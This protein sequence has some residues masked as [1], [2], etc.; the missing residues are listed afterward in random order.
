M[1]TAA[2]DAAAKRRATYADVS[3]TSF[4]AP[5]VS[6][7]VAAFLSVRPEFVGRPERV[8]Q[9]LVDSAQPL[10][11]ERQFEG[12]GLLDIMRALQSV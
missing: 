3:G 1:A 11:R 6:G 2:S 7:A 5:H 9:I 8:K 12:G 10:G 4:A